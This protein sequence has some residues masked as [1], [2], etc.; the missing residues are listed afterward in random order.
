MIPS[1]CDVAEMVRS[2]AQN[3]IAR[4]LLKE[5]DV[6]LNAPGACPVRTDPGSLRAVLRNLLDNA[7]KYTDPGGS[8]R[9][10]CAYLGT[11]AVVTISDDG[12]GMESSEHPAQRPGTRGEP[13]GGVGLR[14]AKTLAVRL[15]ATLAVDSAIGQGTSI[16]L[17]LPVRADVDAPASEAIDHAATSRR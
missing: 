9:V 13:G 12:V 15:G 2:L 14:L 7:V 6:R 1:K 5:I 16:S 11:T 17:M 8:I 4:G 10:A 3:T